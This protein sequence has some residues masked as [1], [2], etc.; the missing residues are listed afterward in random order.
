[1]TTTASEDF[2]AKNLI[3]LPNSSRFLKKHE[4]NLEKNLQSSCC[5]KTVSENDFRRNVLF[6]YGSKSI[7]SKNI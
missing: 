1:M 5:R 4:K 7:Y 6:L 2:F 3:T